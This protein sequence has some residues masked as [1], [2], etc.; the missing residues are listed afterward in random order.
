MIILYGE[1]FSEG[2][3]N[4]IKLNRFAPFYKAHALYI[5]VNVELYPCRSKDVYN[6]TYPKLSHFATT[7]S[8]CL[9]VAAHGQTDEHA[10]REL[11]TTRMKRATCT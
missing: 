11:R 7:G 1:S 9:P 8:P 2:Y 3:V 4:F 10:A 6:K 5:Y